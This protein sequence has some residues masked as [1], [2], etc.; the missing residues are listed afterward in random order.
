MDYL[1]VKN[2]EKYH[3]N[4]KDRNL[5]WCKA[6]FTMLNADPEFECLCETDKWRFMAFVMLEIQIKRPVMLDNAYLSKKGFD[7]KNRPI[8]LTLQMLHNFVDIVP[9]FS[10][11]R[12]PEEDKEEELEV[13][14]NSFD[15]KALLS[16]YPNKDGS[17]KALDRLRSTVKSEADWADIN[18][19]LTNYLKS[20]RV[21]NGF[22]KN[23]ST[24]FNN[25]RDW[26]DFTEPQKNV[27]TAVESKP[28][29]VKQYFG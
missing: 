1:H 21:K 28:F 9:H 20:Q 26:V 5:V 3:P 18:K 27:G 25:W 29:P 13:D 14:K 10:E 22:I 7:L 12:S 16:K 2:I 24:W 17:K 6:Y 8:S 19:A 15:F 11:V 4:Y 23:A